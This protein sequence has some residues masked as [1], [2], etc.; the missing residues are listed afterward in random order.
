[1]L[2]QQ[3]QRQTDH[4]AQS[5]PIVPTPTLETFETFEN[6]TK[7]INEAI[8]THEYLETVKHASAAIDKTQV[9]ALIDIR[10]YAYSLQGCYEAACID[11]QRMIHLAPH[12]AD[13]YMRLGHIHTMYGKQRSAIAAYNDGLEN[14]AAADQKQGNEQL[15]AA[16]REAETISQKR[17]NFVSKLPLEIGTLIISLLPK[18]AIA[19]CISVSRAWRQRALES[20]ASWK[21]LSVDEEH[22]DRQL[23][24]VVGYTAHHVEH[25]TL[26]TSNTAT[27]SKYFE[28]MRDYKF[29]KLH[30]LIMTARATANLRSYSFA[31]ATALWQ[32][33]PTLKYLDFKSDSS[34]S[35]ITL[36]EVLLAC[37]NVTD[38]IFTTNSSMSTMGCNFSD[39]EENYA[40][41]NL[42]LKSR[43]ITGQDIQ[44]LLQRC[45]HLRRLVI[46]GCE[47]SVM[48]SIIA[49]AHNLEILGYDSECTIPQLND[50]VDDEE[51]HRRPFNGI[52]GLRMLYA[53]GSGGTLIEASSIL[54]LLYKNRLTLTTVHA[55]IRGLQTGELHRMQSTYRDFHFGSIKELT[56]TAFTGVQQFMMDGIRIAATL[57][58][59]EAKHV[60]NVNSMVNTLMELPSLTEFGL[61]HVDTTYGRASLERLFK[62]YAQLAGAP[63]MA[64][65]S[66][67]PTLQSIKL[68][69]CDEIHDDLLATLAEIKT[70]HKVELA[71][72]RFVTTGGFNE[73]I[74]RVSDRLTHITLGEMD[75]VTDSFISTTLGGLPALTSIELVGLK[76]ATNQSVQALVDKAYPRLIELKVKNCP[77]ITQESI[78]YAKKKARVVV[79]E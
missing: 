24:S 56:F 36:A 40:L 42:Q 64:S 53:S 69:F 8:A 6:L 41:S 21:I 34:T 75:L 23:A 46:N 66:L 9:I 25:L 48:E 43:L 73:F 59:L 70:L 15:Q 17:V 12:L 65:S 38:L 2:Q 74:R 31:L 29:K 60:H 45:S 79:R 39:L 10:A 7:K 28:C 44:V 37:N 78:Q 62:R 68:R 4:D 13:G 30:S 71:G 67:S 27:R 20:A 18:N 1:M 49:H 63:L 19:S 61:S 76:N 3:Q 52:K 58:R 26:N 51:G 14:V 11:A 50:T 22:A 47:P 33:R 16:K 55:S 35:A 32:L 77:S 57:E 72:L 5:R 54:P